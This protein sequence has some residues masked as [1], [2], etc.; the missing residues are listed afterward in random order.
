MG[1]ELH[2][3]DYN[4]FAVDEATYARLMELLQKVM[5]GCPSDLDIRD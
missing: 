3:F 2:F 4:N 5:V 1:L